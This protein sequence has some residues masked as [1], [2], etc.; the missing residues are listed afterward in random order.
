MAHVRTQLGKKGEQLVAQYLAD[1]GFVIKEINFA[2][3]CGEIDIIAQRNEVLAFVEVK[4]RSTMYFNISEVVNYSKQ[5]KIIKTAKSY[6][7]QHHLADLVFRFDI[8]LLEA[9]GADFTITYIPNAFAP[10]DNY[11]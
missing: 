5:R 9:Q 7:A 1:K 8:A 10:R 11:A 2:R 4:V 3:R 6:I